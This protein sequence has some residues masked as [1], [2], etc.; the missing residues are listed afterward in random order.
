MGGFR[1][2]E[3]ICMQIEEPCILSLLSRS[4]ESWWDAGKGDGMRSS[5]S[6]QSVVSRRTLCIMYSAVR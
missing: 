1:G 4:R 5:N 3:D 2:W 6:A